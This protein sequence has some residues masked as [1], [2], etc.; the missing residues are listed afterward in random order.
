MSLSFL[1]LKNRWPFHFVPVMACA[2]ALS[3]L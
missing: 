1:S 3:D 2:M